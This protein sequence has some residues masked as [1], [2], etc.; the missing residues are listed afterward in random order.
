MTTFLYRRNHGGRSVEVARDPGGSVG[1]TF[2]D[3]KRLSLMI[4]GPAAN[5]FLNMD[6]GSAPN[7]VE[8]LLDFGLGHEVLRPNDVGRAVAWAPNAVETIMAAIQALPPASSR[9][10]ATLLSSQD[11]A[12]QNK[13]EAMT[14][15]RASGGVHG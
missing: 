10:L 9:R 2:S 5:Y 6:R 3:D 4:R 12:A 14:A 7:I 8:K 15:H 13:V 1:F 11:I